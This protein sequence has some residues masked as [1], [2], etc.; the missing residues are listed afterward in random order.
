MFNQWA[1]SSA[2]SSIS[3]CGCVWKCCV[4]LN[5]MVLLIIIPM[6][7]CYFI[8]NI[9]YFQTYPCCL[10]RCFHFS[11]DACCVTQVFA[12]SLLRP[13]LWSDKVTE[14]PGK[15]SRLG[16]LVCQGCSGY[17]WALRTKQWVFGCSWAPLFGHSFSIF[18]GCSSR[19]TLVM[20]GVHT[21]K[22]S[23]PLVNKHS[24]WKWS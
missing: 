23:Y 11:K 13:N 6:K 7:N 4:S 24:Y 3:S 20:A 17:A 18:S 22:N 14:A 1:E 16:P 8:G 10:N 15:E 5:P 12:V 19:L 2:M 21:C 9:P